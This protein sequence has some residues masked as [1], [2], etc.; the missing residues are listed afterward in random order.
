MFHESEHLPAIVSSTSIRTQTSKRTALSILILLASIGAGSQAANASTSAGFDG[1]AELPRILIQTAM[2]N[3]P[4]PGITT[5]VNRGGNLQAAL[6]SARCGDTILLEAGATFTS[7]TGY[8]IFP[9]K[10]CDNAHWIIVR[11]SSDD[12]LLPAEGSRLTPCYAG[13][14]SLPGRPGFNCTLTKNV[15][16]KL[17]MNRRGTGPVIFAAGANH[18]RLIG[19]ELTRAQGTGFVYALATHPTGAVTSNIIY[20]RLWFH[21]TAQDDTTR[22]VQLGGS[23]YVSVIDSFLTD[24]H[25]AAGGSCNDSQAI[26][27]GISNQP[28]GP[29]KIVDNFLEAATEN[30]LFGGGGATHTPSDIQISRNHLFKPLTWMKGRAGFVGGRNGTPFSVKNLFELKN[31]QRVLLDGNIMENTWGG[32]SQAG[33]S[34]LL[35]PKNPSRA[36]PCPTCNVTDVT[37]RYNYISHMGAGMQITNGLSDDGSLPSDGG[38]YSIHD[39]VFDDISGTTYRGPGSFAQVSTAPHAPALHDVTIN[40]VTAF[41]QKT[42]LLVGDVL[43]MNAAMSNFVFANSILNAGTNPVWSTGAEGTL[44][45]AVHDSP[46]TTFNECFR[47]YAFSHNAMISIPSI[48]PVTAW[49]AINFFPTPATAVQF[50]NFNGGSGGNY[51]L[52]SASPYKGAG[53]DGKDLGA[54]VSAISAAIARAR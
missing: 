45:C 35:T 12:S 38:R 24:F 3:T 48:A 44:N 42:L 8:F 30:I 27:G 25:C 16:A 19:L 26:N 5:T 29:Y 34:I 4:A 37:I 7:P 49:P 14:S 54:D 28:M 47:S 41:P 20:D 9:K 21:G 43:S 2:A 39:V 33:Y 52:Q 6:N 10:N 51:Q 53:T 11:T 1:P 50:V 40:H 18:Y 46:L 36:T 22:G 23:S 13:V 15:S 31:A 32:F 17:E